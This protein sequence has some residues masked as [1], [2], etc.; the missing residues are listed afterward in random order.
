MIG[1][2]NKEVD[3][4]LSTTLGYY[5]E[6]ILFVFETS[7]TLMSLEM[8]QHA[9]AL[10][11]LCLASKAHSQFV[12]GPKSS[13]S[14][15]NAVKQCPKTGS[16]LLNYQHLKSNP[17]AP[18]Y[19]NQLGEGESAWIEG[20]AELSP[21]LSRQGCF[22]TSDLKISI[23]IVE[24]EYRSVYR[25]LTAC[26]Y[27]MY[28]GLKD[29]S[30]YCIHQV[31]RPEIYHASVNDSF[32]SIPCFNNA[33]DSCGGHSYMSVYVISEE[34]RIHWAANEPSSHL[35][36]Y[37]K[38]KH[39]IFE[40]FTASC[41]T[42]QSGL[43]N[44]YICTNSAWS[45]LSP[46]NCSRLTTTS[47]TYCI[48]ERM[49]TRTEA[50]EGCV[51]NNGILADLGAETTTPALLNHNFKYWIGAYRTF[52]VSEIY[53]DKE[54]VCLSA[55]RVD[56][57]LH[58]EPDD[59]SAQKYYLCESN[60]KKDSKTTASPVPYIVP[61]VLMVIFIILLIL[62]IVYRRHKKR[63]NQTTRKLED[64]YDAIYEADNM[65][66]EQSFS[67][68]PGLNT[69]S[70]RLIIKS[71]PDTPESQTLKRIILTNEYKKLYSERQ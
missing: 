13:M 31:Q 50:Y 2:L 10:V 58:L 29:T 37:V 60:S 68:D 23:R 54:T 46:T 40:A 16:T 27:Y 38:R 52:G 64:N 3:F 65:K 45:R 6:H 41:H 70:K 8:G 14:K 22:T 21:F 66:H 35:C 24:I 12:A 42:F 18:E 7:K 19:L 9:L 51:M 53:K 47:G 62:F 57:M 67:S 33:I 1:C 36:V 43:I 71:E 17:T 20:Y 34:K 11:I 15:Q 63:R 49:S 44:G 59:C 55:T 5:F 30:C 48:M 39:Y 4:V 28:I 69:D 61:S 26:H 32:C 25:C 56:N